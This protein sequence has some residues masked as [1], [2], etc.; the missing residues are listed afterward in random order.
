MKFNSSSSTSLLRLSFNTLRTLSLEQG[1][2]GALGR[3]AQLRWSKLKIKKG[4]NITVVSDTA[5]HKPKIKV[6]FF[7]KHWA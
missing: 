4:D 5:E 6:F 1:S 7:T 3:L 2:A